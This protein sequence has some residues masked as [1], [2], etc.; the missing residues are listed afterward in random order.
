MTV[1]IQSAFALMG[2]LAHEEMYIKYEEAVVICKMAAKMNNNLTSFDDICRHFV[3]VSC[4]N[5]GTHFSSFL[6]NNVCEYKQNVCRYHQN[7]KGFFPNGSIWAIRLAE[8]LLQGEFP[9]DS[10]LSVDKIKMNLKAWLTVG[11]PQIDNVEESSSDSSIIEDLTV[12][13]QEL[14]DAVIKLSIDSEGYQK[15]NDLR[16]A[17]LKDRVKSLQ[18]FPS[19]QD[20]LNAVHREAENKEKLD[21]IFNSS[22]IFDFAA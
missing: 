7:R 19:A 3:S 12:Q 1:T 13:L 22:E 5:T 2:R 17:Y 10:I 16:F 4:S 15:M 14:R 21:P 8:R 9:I 11:Y 6:C 18:T 20:V